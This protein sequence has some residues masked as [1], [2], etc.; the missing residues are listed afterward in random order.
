[1]VPA[2]LAQK[3]VDFYNMIVGFMASEWTAILKK[4]G[5]EHPQAQSKMLLTLLWDDICEPIWKTRYNIKHNT[6]NFSSLDKISSL[7]DK[8]MWYHRHQDKVLNYHHQFLI[9]YTLSDVKRLTRIARTS[10]VAILDSAMRFHKIKCGQSAHHQ[11]T[12]YDWM[13]HNNKLRS[14]RLIGEGLIDA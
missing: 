8:L 9:D 5:V 13:S 2:I 10:K 11:S 1:M 7:A 14:R 4:L 3:N 12:I 6:N